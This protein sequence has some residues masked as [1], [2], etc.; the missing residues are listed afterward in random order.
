MCRNITVLRGLEPPA[1]ASEID[2]AARQFIRKVAGLHSTSQ[3]ARDDV[4]HA[5]DQIARATSELLAQLPAPR[6]VPPGP[7]GR[8]RRDGS[9]KI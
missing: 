4:R 8:R 2:D 5:I 1:S 6:R 7:P 3:L 9:D